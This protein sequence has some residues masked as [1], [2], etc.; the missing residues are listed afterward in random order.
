VLLGW[1][2][3]NAACVAEVERLTGQPQCG[4]AGLSLSQAEVLA[5]LRQCLEQQQAATNTAQ[6]VGACL[7][8]MRTW[9][10]NACTST[11]CMQFELSLLMMSCSSQC[12]HHLVSECVGTAAGHHFCFSLAVVIA[13]QVCVLPAEL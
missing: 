1:L 11:L 5:C 2:Y 7:R 13:S 10:F 3:G 8:M 4:A 6:Q 9:N 12:V